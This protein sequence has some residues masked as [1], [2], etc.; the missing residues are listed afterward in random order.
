MTYLLG[1][2]RTLR[3]VDKYDPTA[4]IQPV[5]RSGPGNRGR[6]R[7]RGREGQNRGAENRQAG[8]ADSARRHPAHRSRGRRQLPLRAPGT[9]PRPHPTA[10]RR[11]PRDQATGFQAFELRVEFDKAQRHIALSATITEAVARAS[12][13]QE[14]STRRASCLKNSFPSTAQRTQGGSTYPRPFIASKNPGPWTGLER[15]FLAIPAM[16]RSP[17]TGRSANRR[18]L[19]QE[20]NSTSSV[21]RDGRRRMR[22][23]L[24]A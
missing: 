17:T 9:N 6:R 18:E 24:C 23:A 10:A 8:C 3:E 21:G 19:H 20:E 4:G 13:T 15:D 16:T 11:D 14:P 2:R 22:R 1:R 12:R 5:V 7:Y